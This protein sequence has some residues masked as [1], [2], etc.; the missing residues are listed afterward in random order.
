M[1]GLWHRYVTYLF[2][3][4][5]VACSCQKFHKGAWVQGHIFNSTYRKGDVSS[6]QTL[7]QRSCSNDIK[8][9]SL[10]IEIAK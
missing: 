7:E 3:K 4:G 2:C 9:W 10:L 6:H 1:H 5:I 8:V